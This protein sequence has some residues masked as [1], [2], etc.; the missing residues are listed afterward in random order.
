MLGEELPKSL[1]ARHA[2]GLA[3]ET[4]VKMP[5]PVGTGSDVQVV[6]AFTVPMMTGLPKRPKPTA[7]QSEVVAHEMALRPLTP[8]GIA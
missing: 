5:T 8:E 1:T 4:P 2:A 7:V 3:H 6:P